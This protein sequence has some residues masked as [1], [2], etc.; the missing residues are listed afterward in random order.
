MGRRHEQLF[1]QRRLTDGQQTHEKML[2]ITK[3]QGNANQNH[4]ER[5]PH[6]NQ[7]HKKQQVLGRMWRKGNPL[8]LLVG[9]QTGAATLEISMEVPQKVENRTTSNCITGYLPQRYK[10]SDPKGHLHPNVY[11]SK[12]RNSQTIERTQMSLDKWMK[13]MWY[14]YTMEYYSA[15]KK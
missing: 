1:S 9:M 3:H 11:S 4:N 12:V 5:S 14:I 13:M 2:N 7:Q 15:D 6:I 10:C 8:A